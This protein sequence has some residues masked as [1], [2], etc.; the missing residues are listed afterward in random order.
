MSHT[1][2]FSICFPRVGTPGKISRGAGGGVKSLRISFLEAVYGFR[3]SY[4]SLYIFLGYEF[5]FM[6]VSGAVCAFH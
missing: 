1:K 5:S 4:L 2:P 6:A 3:V